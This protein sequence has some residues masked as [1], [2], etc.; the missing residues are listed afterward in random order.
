MEVQSHLLDEIKKAQISDPYF[1]RLKSDIC[2]GKCPKFV[3][4]DDGILSFRVCI[5]VPNY[6]DLN[7]KI[8]NKTHNT[9]YSIHPEG[10]KMY[11]DLG[12]NFWC[13]NLKNEVAYYTSHCLTYQKVKFEHYCPFGEL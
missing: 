11:K 10:S 8:M 4:R 6:K 5:S 9:P 3:I 12:Q 7:E 2:K 1:D 13:N